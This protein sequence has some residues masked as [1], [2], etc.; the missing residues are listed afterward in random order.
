MAQQQDQENIPEVTIK[1][2]SIRHR[3]EY[4]QCGAAGTITP[5]SD[6]APADQVVRWLRLTANGRLNVKVDLT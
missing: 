1:R 3:W 5:W 2:D 4:R 6:D